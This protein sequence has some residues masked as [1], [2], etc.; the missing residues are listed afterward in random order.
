MGEGLTFRPERRE[1]QSKTVAVRLQLYKIMM[2]QYKPQRGGITQPMVSTIG[3]NRHPQGMSP[4]GATYHHT[5]IGYNVM[6]P[7]Q[8]SN[9][10]TIDNPYSYGYN[11]ETLS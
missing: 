7:L 11:R 9:A 2:M 4:V 6:P 1:P 3:T 8:G 5:P 10:F